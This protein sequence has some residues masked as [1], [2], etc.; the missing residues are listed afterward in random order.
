MSKSMVKLIGIT[1]ELN[2]TSFLGYSEVVDLF[3]SSGLNN[4]ISRLPAKSRIGIE[5]LT[6]NDWREINEIMSEETGGHFKASS[7]WDNLIDTVQSMEHEIIFLEDKNLIRKIIDAQKGLQKV[8]Q[9]EL[10]IE[11]NESSSDYNLK[12]INHNEE[13]NNANINYR[14]IHEIERDKSILNKIL[15]NNLDLA[16][17]GVGH[18]DLWIHEERKRFEEYHI[19]KPEIFDER[20]VHM[21]FVENAEPN[22]EIIIQN[23]NLIRMINLLKTGRLEPEKNPDY[24]GIFNNN[25]HYF[26]GYF[27]VFLKNENSGL[28]I[29]SLGEAKITGKFLENQVD[30]TKRYTI[31]ESRALKG[32]IEY[33]GAGL[34]SLLFNT[35]EIYGRFHGTTR[36]GRFSNIFLMTKEKV[37]P[38][39]LSLMLANSWPKEEKHYKKFE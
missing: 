32:D 18:S 38:A 14:K 30:F 13:I 37:S 11:E 15:E 26:E 9:H 31:A 29:D 20:N 6:E 33:K 1:H 12:L 19:D 10:F 21:T 2:L 24:V 5:W 27:E 17:V 39:K 8:N 36:L 3:P 35:G 25:T 28:I 16:I 34:S 23:K 22:S 7:Y 4:Y